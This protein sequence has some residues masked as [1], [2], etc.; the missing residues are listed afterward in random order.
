MSKVIAVYEAC[1][2]NAAVFVLDR[3]PERARKS[4]AEELAAGGAEV[5]TLDIEEWR[6]RGMYCDEHRATN[7]PPDWP[8]NQPKQVGAGL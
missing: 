7:G 5:V 8:S 3:D 4:A 6:R 1:G 2:C